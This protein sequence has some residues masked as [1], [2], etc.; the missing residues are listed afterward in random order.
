[1]SY[2]IA[3]LV[4]SLIAMPC[5]SALDGFCGQPARYKLHLS[6]AHGVL[7]RACPQHGRG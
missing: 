1:M 6:V 7:D 3:S 5:L 4:D 2:D